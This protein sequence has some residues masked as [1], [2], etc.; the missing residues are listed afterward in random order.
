M[1]RPYEWHAQTG[2]LTLLAGPRGVHF[3]GPGKNAAGDGDW[4]FVLTVG[5]N[6]SHGNSP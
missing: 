3:T 1:V 2:A 6:A 4:V 5:Y